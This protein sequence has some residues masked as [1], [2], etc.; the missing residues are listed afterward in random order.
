METFQAKINASG[1]ILV[2]VSLRRELDLQTDDDVLLHIENGNLV[3]TPLKQSLGHI[4]SQIQ[5]HNIHG[6]QL[7]DMLH[8]LREEI[9]R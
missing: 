4:Q 3:V 5:F 6:R 8:I 9:E 1:R 2:P 7:T